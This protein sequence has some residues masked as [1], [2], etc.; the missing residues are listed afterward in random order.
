M[1]PSCL[2]PGT[3][4]KAV[5]FKTRRVTCVLISCCLLGLLLFFGAFKFCA[6]I[7]PPDNESNQA[8]VTFITSNHCS[9]GRY[10]YQGINFVRVDMDIVGQ[11]PRFQAVSWDYFSSLIGTTL[12]GKQPRQ[13]FLFKLLI[14]SFY[15]VTNGN[16]ARKAVKTSMQGAIL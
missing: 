12:S 16:S 1:S 13:A 9:S 10:V 5:Q 11:R 7:H 15:D 3:D 4:P 2:L 14:L 6:K 8:A